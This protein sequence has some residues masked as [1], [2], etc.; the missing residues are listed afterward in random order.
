MP[1]IVTTL[2]IRD[3]HVLKNIEDGSQAYI[4]CFHLLG[5]GCAGAAVL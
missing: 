3:L 4:L 2:N 1:N 5:G